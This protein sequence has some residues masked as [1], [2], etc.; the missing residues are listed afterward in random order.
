M[1]R[2]LSAGAAPAVAGA[3][4]FLTALAPPA[5]AGAPQIDAGYLAD[6]KDLKT[7]VSYASA[8]D[9]TDVSLALIPPAP[10]G[11]PAITLT[12]RARFRGRSVD[13]TR[14]DGIVVRAHYALRSDD[15]K[16]TIEAM[17][18]GHEMHMTIDPHDNGSIVLPFYPAT[19]GYSG[20]AAAGDEIPVAYFN[21]TPED[22][23]ALALA[24]ELTG[25][26]L[27]TDFTLTPSEIAA[28]KQFARTVLPPVSSRL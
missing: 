13:V 10:A 27:W 8:E 15:R 6:L 21:V 26:V 24:R 16:R 7:T 9:R 12:F 28:L 2:L 20:F 22:L 4:L 17:T 5:G 1:K 23:R 25:Q 14:L 3:L 18:T 19:W 11:G